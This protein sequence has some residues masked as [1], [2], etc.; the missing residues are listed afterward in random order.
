[1]TNN[2]ILIGF[3]GVGK[4]TIARKITQISDYYAIDTDDLIQ[5]FT[6]RKIKNIFDTE[7]E[8]YF[9]QLEQK[10]ANWIQDSISHT[11]ISV[12]GGFYKVNNLKKLGVVVYLKSDFNSIYNRILSSP[13]AKNK[14]KK[15]PLF[16]DLKN[17][18]ILYDKRIK[19]YQTIADI[20]IDVRNKN[21]K[22]IAKEILKLSLKRF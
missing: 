12:G 18:K 19:T 2:I 7:G 20:T 10:T 8:K 22:T 3:M 4:G 9:R 14:L 11:I 6:N 15:R 16:Q 13:N 21:D 5:S 17:A 1:M